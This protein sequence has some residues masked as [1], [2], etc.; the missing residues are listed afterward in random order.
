VNVVAEHLAHGRVDMQLMRRG[1]LVDVCACIYTSRCGRLRLRRVI[2]L[3][4]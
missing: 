1:K 4:G 3:L 2:G